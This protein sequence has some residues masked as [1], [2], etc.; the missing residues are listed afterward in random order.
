[1]EIP[2]VTRTSDDDQFRKVPFPEKIRSRPI[3]RFPNVPKIPVELINTG[4]SLFPNA[5]G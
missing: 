1:M 2:P 5:P 3:V 4:V